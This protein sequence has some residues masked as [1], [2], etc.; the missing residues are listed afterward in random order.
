[1]IT[2][3]EN[4]CVIC[5]KPA[6]HIHH[7]CEGNSR[8]ELSEKYDMKC[9][10]CANCHNLSKDSVHLNSKMKA[11]SNIIGQLY[12]ERQWLINKYQLPF[13][14]LDEEAREEFRKIFG[15]SFL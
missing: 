11:M 6:Q 12:F 14:D 15:K 8:R 13:E 3:Y 2:K 7:L 1:M 5:G 10:L 4:L 9:P